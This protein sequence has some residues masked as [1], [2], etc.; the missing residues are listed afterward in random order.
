MGSHYA[1]TTAL[2][3]ED[4]RLGQSSPGHGIIREELHIVSI[5]FQLL[6]LGLRVAEA[7]YVKT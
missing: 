5:G 1:Y 3:E 6:Q 2:H 4:Q 7:S